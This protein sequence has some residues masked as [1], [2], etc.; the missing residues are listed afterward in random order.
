M[1]ILSI[2]IPNYNRLDKLNNLL[3]II[4]QNINSNRLNKKV[5]ICISDDCSEED[6]GFTINKKMQEYPDVAICYRRN[7]LNMGMDYNFLQ[8]VLM[9]NAKYC[10]IIGNDDLP[11]N[12][13]ITNIIAI[14]ERFLKESIDFVVTPFRCY[15]YDNNYIR[16][17][18]PLGIE[19]KKEILFNTSNLKNLNT[20][21]S[22]V[23][24]NSALFGFL[25]N[26]VFKRERWVQHGDMFADKM[27][28]IFIQMYMNI[29]TLIEGAIYLYT[30]IEIISNFIDEETNQTTD[31]KYRIAIG[32][33]GVIN[34]FFC[35]E[36]HI[37]MQKIMV[38]EYITGDIW[39]LPD[40]STMKNNILQIASIKN[41]L[42][43]RYFVKANKREERFSKKTV[44]IYGAGNYGKK[45]LRKLE[46]YCKRIIGFCD[47][48]E[49]K[50][51]TYIAKYPVFGIEEL[52]M[53]HKAQECIV[54]V[55]N[56]KSLEDIINTLN[57]RGIQDI[58]LVT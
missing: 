18:Y 26:T 9:A 38:D 15:D 57:S 53:Y 44:I 7:K 50:Q 41:D 39:E 16:T 20:I 19:N 25:S 30:P 24:H 37:R 54:V 34:Y 52:C 51:G 35:G 12:T 14:L 13:G 6:P 45:A 8:S 5:E 4:I 46:G 49:N 28:S 3:S 43:R 47:S 23:Q 22:Q 55:A 56:N 21:I 17:V 42:Y 1:K 58:A 36:N 27:D 29:Q 48:D 11:T 40:D 33:N 2:C 10:W 32:L 31:R